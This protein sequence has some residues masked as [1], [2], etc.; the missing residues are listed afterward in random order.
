[1]HCSY[2]NHEIKNGGHR[3]RFCGSAAESAHHM[4]FLR[5]LREDMGEFNNGMCVEGVETIKIIRS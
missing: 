4:H 2:E 3:T 5:L 1:M